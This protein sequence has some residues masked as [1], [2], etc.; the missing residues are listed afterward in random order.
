MKTYKISPDIEVNYSV[1]NNYGKKYKFDSLI[2]LEHKLDFYQAAFNI[3]CLFKAFRLNILNLKDKYILDDSIE[4]RITR[5]NGQYKLRVTSDKTDKVNYYN[6]YECLYL[7][8]LLLTRFKT[9]QLD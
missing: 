4:I 8:D 5:K 7:H 1:Y 9:F 2:I 3:L 6:K